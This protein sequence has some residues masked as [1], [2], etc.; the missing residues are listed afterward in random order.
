MIILHLDPDQRSRRLLQRLLG[1]DLDTAGASTLGHA[2]ELARADRP[3]VVV[4]E[5]AVPTGSGS[6]C[7]PEVLRGHPATVDV[8]LVV[9]TAQGYGYVADHVERL[10][11]V[12]V[13]KS[14]ESFGVVSAIRLAQRHLPRLSGAGPVFLPRRRS[15]PGHR[16]ASPLSIHPVLPGEELEGPTASA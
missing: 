10:G 12:F 15:W 2:L 7:A 11:G 3:S 13:S 14:G 16:N 5:Y 4:T 1:P 9:W 8:P 6:T